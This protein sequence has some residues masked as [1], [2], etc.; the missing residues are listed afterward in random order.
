MG[1]RIS[2]FVTEDERCFVSMK[3]TMPQKSNSGPKSPTAWHYRYP[4][5]QPERKE[6]QEKCGRKCIATHEDG[7]LL[8]PVC[9]YRSRKGGAKRITCQVDVAG[10]HAAL[11]RERLNQ[12]DERLAEIRRKCKKALD[13]SKRKSSFRAGLRT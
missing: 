5:T 2:L 9:Q 13:D 1:R 3:Q 6:L 7:R 4:Q 12:D 8:D 10:C 11:S